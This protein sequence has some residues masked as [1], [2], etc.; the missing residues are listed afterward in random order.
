MMTESPTTAGALRAVMVEFSE[1]V[2]VLPMAMPCWPSPGG[3]EV[4]IVDVHG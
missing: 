1:T 3:Q 4:N 2:D